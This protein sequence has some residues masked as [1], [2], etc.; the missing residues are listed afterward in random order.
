MESQRKRILIIGGYGMV[1]SNLA[2]LLRSVDSSIELVLSG[3]NPQNGEQLADELKNAETAYVNLEEGFDLS[4]L[5][6][7]DLIITAM[8]DRSNISR[9]IAISNGISCITVSELADQISPTTFLCLQKPIVAPIVFAGHWQAGLLT[10]AVK[11]LAAKFDHITRIEMAGLYDKKDRVG[12]EVANDVNDFIGQALIRRDG[13][14][15]S[16]PAK[17]NQREI[18]LYNRS[19][20]KGHP[21]S[22]LDVPSIAAFTNAANIRFDFAIGESIGSSRGSEASHDLYIDM[23]GV[24][25]TGKKTKLRK[26]KFSTDRRGCLFN[27][28]KDI[29]AKWKERNKGRRPV[30]SGNHCSGN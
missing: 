12:P 17:D 4:K 13:K 26:R 22:T 10:L 14:W 25:F 7:I 1:G 24:L 15:L 30:S 8:Q 23:E 5:G 29:G 3:R 9:E 19:L 27:N 16:V 21:L 11:H 6:N 2:R 28:R 20:A 18:C